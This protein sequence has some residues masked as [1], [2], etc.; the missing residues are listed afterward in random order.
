[1]GLFYIHET[2]TPSC[3]HAIT[4][5]PSGLHSMAQPLS[6][7]PYG[8]LLKVSQTPNQCGFTIHGVMTF[9]EYPPML[10]PE[11]S[12]DTPWVLGK[13]KTANRTEVHGHRELKGDF[14]NVHSF[15]R[16]SLIFLLRPIV[17]GKKKK[18][19]LN[20]SHLGRPKTSVRGN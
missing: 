14:L 3:P 9:H 4:I 20:S 7:T 19:P 18:K 8:C 15:L 6:P 2:L 16:T 5:L 13:Y 12:P 11:E 1:M 17:G 10:S